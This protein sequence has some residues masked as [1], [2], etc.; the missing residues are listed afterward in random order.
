MRVDRVHGAL[1]GRLFFWGALALK[2]V[3]LVGIQVLFSVLICQGVKD[4]V[5]Q[6]ERVAKVKSLPPRLE[7]GNGLF[8]FAFE[9]ILFHV[10]PKCVY[11]AVP[12]QVVGHP[13]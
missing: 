5:H 1:V 2:A 12:K 10:V 9:L 7:I 8:P 6:R 13:P 4:V 11:G 3:G